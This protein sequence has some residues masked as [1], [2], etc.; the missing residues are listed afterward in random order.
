MGRWTRGE[1]WDFVHVAVE[2]AARLA[3]IEVQPDEPKATT[4]GFPLRTLRWFL[5]QGIDVTRG[6]TDNDSTYRS[7]HFRKALRWLAVRHIYTRH[8]APTIKERQSGSSS[9]FCANGRNHHFRGNE[10]CSSSL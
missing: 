10:S 3:F 9:P 5:A 7:S 1:G 8:Y 4:T 2:D 6:M